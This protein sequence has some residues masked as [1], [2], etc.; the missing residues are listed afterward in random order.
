MRENYYSTPV[1]SQTRVMNN[2]SETLSNYFV[3]FILLKYEF[4]NFE[5]LFF[6][7]FILL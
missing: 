3:Q 1:M 2:N 7:S 5:T 6:D 4:L